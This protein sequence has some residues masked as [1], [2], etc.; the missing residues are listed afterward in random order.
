MIEDP[1][2]Q[3]LKRKASDSFEQPEPEAKRFKFS[4]GTSISVSPPA[5]APAA[6]APTYG[7]EDDAA[8]KEALM[9]ELQSLDMELKAL[10]QAT[11]QVTEK[12]ARPPAHRQQSHR[13][14]ARPV[15]VFG[16]HPKPQRPAMPVGLVAPSLPKRK[17]QDPALPP[18]PW[19]RSK[20]RTSV[21]VTTDDAWKECS[22]VLNVR[23]FLVWSLSHIL[24]QIN[25]HPNAHPFKIPV[26]PV[27]LGIPDYFQRIAHPMDLGTIKKRL[28]RKTYKSVSEFIED[29]RLVWANAISYNSPLHE[30]HKMAQTLSNLFES[31]AVKLFEMTSNVATPRDRYNEI[32]GTYND[33]ETQLLAL[34]EEETLLG[35]P[36]D[37]LGD[38]SP[39]LPPPSDD[40]RPL[41][42]G[43]RLRIH[44]YLNV[45]HLIDPC[46]LILM[47][48][49]TSTPSS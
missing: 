12:P 13:P 22:N 48:F 37:E 31:R 5:P 7:G 4:L 1:S 45:R 44:Q 33:L 34:Q 16:D 25:L 6:A 29:M 19:T 46:Q 39:P 21:R 47:H 14:P 43:E 41:T 24:Q 30:V 10:E 49:R 15:D 35:T 40:V 8:V 11:A 26:D 3:N 23:Y 28:A 18:P 36:F 38:S 42:Y 2:R 27:K 32:V 9:R 17:P 20:R